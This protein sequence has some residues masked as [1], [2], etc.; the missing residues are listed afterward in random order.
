[1]SSIDAQGYER[2]YVDGSQVR[3]HR[4]VAVAILGRQL[5]GQ[6]VVHHKNGDRSDNRPENLEIFHSHSEHMKR[7]MTPSIARV[8]GA[9]GNATKRKN[10][11]GYT[12]RKRGTRW[13]GRLTSRKLD[14]RYVGRFKSEEDATE[15]C[16]AALKAVGV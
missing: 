5:T 12:L 4:I 11:K 14:R 13:E 10:A 2:I 3:T 9:K 7:H 15:A 6:E 1:M 8:R 16:L